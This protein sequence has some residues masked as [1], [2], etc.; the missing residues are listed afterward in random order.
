MQISP[1]PSFSKR[2]IKSCLSNSPFSRGRRRIFIGA[3]QR[4]VIATV[5]IRLLNRYIRLRHSLEVERENE[6]AGFVRLGI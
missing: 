5:H 4:C 6:T 2:G 3:W 1:S